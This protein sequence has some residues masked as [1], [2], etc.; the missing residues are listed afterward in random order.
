M[1]RR[2]EFWGKPKPLGYYFRCEVC[3][4]NKF[5]REFPKS[6]FKVFG[7]SNQEMPVCPQCLLKIGAAQPV[8]G[9]TK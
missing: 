3:Y 1:W 6:V 5:A 7:T 9:E 2:F 4:D 8:I